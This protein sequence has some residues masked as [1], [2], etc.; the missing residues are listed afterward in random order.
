MHILQEYTCVVKVMVR[1]ASPRLRVAWFSSLQSSRVCQHLYD[2]SSAHFAA[3][4]VLPRLTQAVVLHSTLMGGFN[5]SSAG[6][7]KT[8]TIHAA[9]ANLYLAVQFPTFAHPRYASA[10]LHLREKSY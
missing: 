6:L 10:E 3:V 2:S 4:L 8:R 1:L 7:V 5:A 9:D